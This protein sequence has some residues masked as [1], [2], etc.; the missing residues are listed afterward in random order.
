MKQVY[1]L[2]L[3][4][5]SEVVLDTFEGYN[6]DNVSYNY[7]VEYDI[8]KILKP[9]WHTFLELPWDRILYFKKKSMHGSVHTDALD[10]TTK[11]IEKNR[12]AWGI[13]WVAEGTGTML[14]WDWEKVTTVGV[15]PGSLNDPNFGVVPKFLP[16][17]S[18]DEIHVLKPNKAYLINATLPHQAF[19][20]NDRKVY[21][22]RTDELNLSWQDVLIL[23][24]D[25][26][27]V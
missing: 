13:N 22:Y 4:P 25:Y 16:K 11:Q 18:P 20:L 23:F 14:F 6:D 24:K 10:E 3:P 27:I 1:E 2:N 8:K 5:F 17:K 12:T 21:S 15:T 9:E 26:I 19:G 7:I